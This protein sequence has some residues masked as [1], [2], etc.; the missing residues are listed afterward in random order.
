MPPLKNTLAALTLALP[1]LSHAGYLPYGLQSNV[2]AETVSSWGWSTC[3]RVTNAQ[4]TSPSLDSWL[5]AACSGDYLMMALLNVQTNTYVALGAGDFS[6]VTG[7]AGTLRKTQTLDHWSNGLNFYR[8]TQTINY[9]GGKRTEYGTWGFTTNGA[10]TLSNNT[11]GYLDNSI[12]GYEIASGQ[13]STGMSFS[14]GTWNV[15]SHTGFYN[16]TGYTGTQWISQFDPVLLKL[17]GPISNAPPGSNPD[18]GN[19]GNPEPTPVPEPSTLA[20]FGL[21]IGGLGLASR[22]KREIA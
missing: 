14:I 19:G 16:T 5:P 7:Y 12:S 4:T 9:N 21:G 3:L 20:L 17:S 11:D 8:A 6:V 1:A 10:I 15:I 2:S 18:P 13:L 22:R